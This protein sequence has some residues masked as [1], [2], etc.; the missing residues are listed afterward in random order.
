MYCIGKLCT[1][2]VCRHYFF[3]FLLLP[4]P[5][6]F[7]ISHHSCLPCLLLW[8]FFYT[9]LNNKVCICSLL[10]C[11]DPL[12]SRVLLARVTSWPPAP[13]YTPCINYIANWQLC[14]CDSQLYVFPDTSNDSLFSLPACIDFPFKY[15]MWMCFSWGQINCSACIVS[16]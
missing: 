15:F 16:T 10:M 14:A 8:T 5:L 2:F 1:I 7:Y 3:L 4:Q 6:L 9:S 11:Q 13:F 12:L